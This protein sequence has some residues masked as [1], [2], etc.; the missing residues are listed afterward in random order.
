MKRW[1]REAAVRAEKENQSSIQSCLRYAKCLAV[2]N[3]LQVLEVC[4]VM[5][6]VCIV[7]EVYKVTGG[8]SNSRPGALKVLCTACMHV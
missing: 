8:T 6:E 7:L 2:C 4:K 3:V 5:H 1:S